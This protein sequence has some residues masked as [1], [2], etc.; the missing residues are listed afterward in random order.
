MGPQFSMLCSLA[1][2][3]RQHTQVPL[4]LSPIQ[5]FFYLQPFL[6]RQGGGRSTFCGTLGEEMRI[7]LAATIVNL[8]GSKQ[9][10]TIQIIQWLSGRKNTLNIDFQIF[11]CDLYLFLKIYFIVL[12]KV[13]FR[14]LD[15]F[16]PKRWNEKDKKVTVVLKNEKTKKLPKIS[17]QRIKKDIKL[18]GR[19][20]GSQIHFIYSR[21]LLV[22]ST[23]QLLQE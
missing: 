10:I 18:F 20:I 19:I 11:F 6:K 23:L 1:N 22:L 8:M 3:A 12:C 4:S 5:R 9:A 15:F 16:Q 14:I 2:F 7:S 21:L 13:I 17:K